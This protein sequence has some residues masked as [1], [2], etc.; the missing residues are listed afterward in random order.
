MLIIIGIFSVPLKQPAIHTFLYFLCPIS[1]LT[2]LFL[3]FFSFE[4]YIILK[5]L[6]NIEG[7]TTSEYQCIM[8]ET[9]LMS[10]FLIKQNK[11]GAE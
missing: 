1:R 6:L 9:L 2:S 5:L 7:V 11:C 3:I 4:P 8:L 10:Y